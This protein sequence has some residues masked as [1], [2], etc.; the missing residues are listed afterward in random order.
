MIVVR[1]KYLVDLHLDLFNKGDMG[2][3]TVSGHR[4]VPS[5]YYKT[6][7]RS[8]LQSI[9]SGMSKGFGNYSPSLIQF[10]ECYGEQAALQRVRLVVEKQLHRWYKAR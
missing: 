9:I 2:L 4:S 1:A 7:A 8:V 6:N 10:Q 5:L 3:R